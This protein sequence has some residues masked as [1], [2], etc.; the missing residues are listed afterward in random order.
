MFPVRR[1]DVIHS[2][3]TGDVAYQ[4]NAGVGAVAHDGYLS[5]PERYRP[6][7]IHP[8]ALL[9]ATPQYMYSDL[10]VSASET[11]YTPYASYDPRPSQVLVPPL[12]FSRDVLLV[13]SPPLAFS[14]T[15][16]YFPSYESHEP[17]YPTF[18]AAPADPSYFY[19]SHDPYY[20]Q[21]PPYG[22]A[23]VPS[24]EI[25]RPKYPISSNVS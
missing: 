16:S 8:Y 13:P 25:Q 2:P 17:V 21:H 24:P 9:P 3:C 7:M 1:S 5:A 12:P 4:T 11:L 10:P 20:P 14:P 22:L 15:H 18:A 23:E 19:A 6:V